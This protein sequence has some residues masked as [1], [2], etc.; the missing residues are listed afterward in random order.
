MALH[1]D[2]L[3]S[4]SSKDFVPSLDEILHMVLEEKMFKYFQYN[5]HFC[6]YLPLGKGVAFHLNEHESPPSK[7]ALC[8]I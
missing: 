1:L 8:H 6:F 3:E 5:L 2:K 7:D 4:P